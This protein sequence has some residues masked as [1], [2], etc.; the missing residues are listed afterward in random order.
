MKR[1]AVVGGKRMCKNGDREDEVERK[2][3]CNRTTE[4]CSRKKKELSQY[5]IGN[6]KKL[7]RICHNMTEDMSPCDRGY[8]TI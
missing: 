5:N 7:Q 1:E 3:S 6:V 4:S 2:C 8:L